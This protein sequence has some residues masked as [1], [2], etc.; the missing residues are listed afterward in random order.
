MSAYVTV[1]RFQ[2]SLFPVNAYIIETPNAVIVVDATLG[3][4]D[5]RALAAQAATMSKPLALAAMIVTHSQPDHYG[6]IAPFL[7]GQFS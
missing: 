1:R 5:G 2:A 7:G 3:V 4:T 6:G